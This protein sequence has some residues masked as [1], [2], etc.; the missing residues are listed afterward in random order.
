[1]QAISIEEWRV[2]NG[3]NN[4]GEQR[5]VSL[6]THIEVEVVAPI[7]LSPPTHSN[8]FHQTRESHAIPRQA[9]RLRQGGCT[10][11]GMSCFYLDSD[12]YILYATPRTSMCF[13]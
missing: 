5:S 2:G 9:Y 1:M 8:K 11:H 10:L 4:V 13:F 3:S 12:A 6:Y 7:P